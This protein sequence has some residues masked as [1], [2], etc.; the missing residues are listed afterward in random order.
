MDNQAV[1]VAFNRTAFAKAPAAPGKPPGYFSDVDPL[2]LVVPLINDLLAR[3]GLAPEKVSNVLT[4]AVHQE[5][6]QGLNMARL[7]VLHEKCGLTNSTGGT[8][9]DR[10]C[11]SSL[12][13]LAFADGMIARNPDQVYICTGV[14]SMSQIPMGGLNPALNGHV[15]GGNAPGFM[16]MGITAENLAKKYGISRQ[17][18][19]KFAL[20]SHQKAAAA[21]ASGH[22]DNEIVPIDGMD[23]DDGIRHDASLEGLAK[24]RPAFK[25]EEKGGT[26]TAGTASQVTDGAAAMMVTSAAFAAENNLVPLAKIVAFGE[27]GCAPEIMGIGPVEASKQAL[28]RAGLSMDD[29]DLIELNE[30]FSAQS[31]AV[32]KEFENQGLTVDFNKVNIDGGAIALGHPLGASGARIVGHLAESL[33]RENKRYGLA[34]MCIGGGHGVAMIIENPNFDPNASCE[35]VKCAGPACKSPGCDM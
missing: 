6:S 9:L 28:A 23:K 24:P 12:Q 11:G 32:L 7:A 17:E 16:N 27:S 10:F 4:G 3:T 35:R 21:Q 18:Q 19:D 8:T 33:V 20:L 29:I 30:A 25:S 34:T 31:L 26:V 15:H 1:I 5:Y 13:A 14:Q 22:F 2:D